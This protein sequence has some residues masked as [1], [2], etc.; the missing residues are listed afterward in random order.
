MR[1]EACHTLYGMYKFASANMIPS[2]AGAGAAH[3]AC[4]DDPAA[5]GRAV[6]L[7]HMAAGAPGAAAPAGQGRRVRP[8]SQGCTDQMLCM[9]T[10]HMKHCTFTAAAAHK[11]G[12]FEGVL[13]HAIQ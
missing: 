13:R 9:F 10:T 2:A 5:G 4:A 7:V 11:A 12:K 3:G 8:A 6:G 1:A